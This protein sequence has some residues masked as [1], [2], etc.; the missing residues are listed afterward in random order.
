MDVQRWHTLTTGRKSLEQGEDWYV[1]AADA[2]DAAD[3]GNLYTGNKY[4]A[5][6]R[7][8]PNLSRL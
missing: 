7:D 8:D 6:I 5:K 3:A 2:A 1:D 4:E